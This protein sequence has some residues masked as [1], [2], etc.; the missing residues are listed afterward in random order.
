MIEEWR[1]TPGQVSTSAPTR[2][3]VL[4]DVWVSTVVEVIDTKKLALVLA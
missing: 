1:R 4:P 3:E 2:E